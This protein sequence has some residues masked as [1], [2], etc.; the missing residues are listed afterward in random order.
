MHILWIALA[1]WLIAAPVAAD[2]RNELATVYAV[3]RDYPG[4]ITKAIPCGAFVDQVAH[5]LNRVDGEVRWGRK[6]REFSGSNP[7]CDALT[8]LNDEDDRT[9]KIIIDIVAISA[10]GGIDSPNAYP[11]WREYLGDNPNNGYWTPPVTADRDVVVY[12]PLQ[13]LPPS[14]VPPPPPPPIPPTP[15][16]PPPPIPVVDL[17]KAITD[18]RLDLIRV[19]TK[20]DKIDESLEAHRVASR[21]LRDRVLGFLRDPRTIGTAIGIMMGRL[22]VP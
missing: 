20:I 10:K 22:V 18:L 8:Y 19:E 15:D 1:G 12:P 7:N 5:R 11:S 4:L 17:L 6:A 16:P 13:P 3:N 21:S 14:P 2:Y 9:R